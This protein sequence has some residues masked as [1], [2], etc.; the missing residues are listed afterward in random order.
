MVSQNCPLLGLQDKRTVPLAV[1]DSSRTLPAFQDGSVVVFAPEGFDFP[2][3]DFDICA[4]L[5]QGNWALKVTAVTIPFD[6]DLCS[7]ASPHFRPN[8]KASSLLE[9]KGRSPWDFEALFSSSDVVCRV[10]DIQ[11]MP[12][13]EGGGPERR[14]MI[15]LLIN[16]KAMFQAGPV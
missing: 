14:S 9:R 11:G 7:K 16:R 10:G 2:V 4:A 3:A 12:S 1:A 15:F 5:L 13:T 6:S 8:S